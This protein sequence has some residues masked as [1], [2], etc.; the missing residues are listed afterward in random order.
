M[1]VI[2]IYII[3]SWWCHQKMAYLIITIWIYSP[4]F[5]TFEVKAEPEKKKE[6]GK[7]G[8]SRERHGREEE[9]GQ[10]KS[11]RH[12]EGKEGRDGRERRDGRDGNRRSHEESGK[13]SARFRKKTWLCHKFVCHPEISWGHWPKDVSGCFFHRTKTLAIL[14]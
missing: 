6:K 4:T 10:G 2:Y 13:A 5:P 7:K 9:E 3:Q 12:D 14:L 1:S 8:E 11:R